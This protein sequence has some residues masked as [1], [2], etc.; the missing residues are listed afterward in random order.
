MD[1]EQGTT[2]RQGRASIVEFVDV[3]VIDDGG[4][5]VFVRLGQINDGE[6]VDV[7]AVVMAPELAKMLSA[8]L[9]EAT[10]EANWEPILS[11]F[12]IGK[13]KGQ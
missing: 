4:P 11:A 10:F 13:G 3:E 9:A 8:R 6:P 7:A 5:K 2:T 12:N 1:Q